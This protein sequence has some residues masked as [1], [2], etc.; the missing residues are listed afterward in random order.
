MTFKHMVALNSLIL[1][2]ACGAQT[3]AP[4]TAAAVGIPALPPIRTA[5]GL[6]RVM[7][8]DARSLIQL[9]GPAVQDVREEGARKLQFVGPVCILDAYLYPPSKGKEPVVT[10]LSARVPDGRDAERAS[11]V[12]ALSRR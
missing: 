5:A 8:R 4:R 10:Y 9:F 6:D 2:S 1:L 3:P 11:C 12:A 7:G